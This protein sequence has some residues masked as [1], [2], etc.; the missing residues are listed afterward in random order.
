LLGA[1]AIYVA[2]R[3]YIAALAGLASARPRLT[4]LFQAVGAIVF[5]FVTVILAL[6]MKIEDTGAVTIDPATITGIQ[7]LRSTL[8]LGS[9][10]MLFGFLVVFIPA[11]PVVVKS[12]VMQAIVKAMQSEGVRMLALAAYTFMA[13]AQVAVA[14]SIYIVAT[15]VLELAT[16]DALGMAVLYTLFAVFYLMVFASSML[17]K[18]FKIKGECIADL[19]REVSAGVC[20]RPTMCVRVLLCV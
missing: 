17:G 3:E 14:S 1:Y 15:N 2:V 16:T 6:L 4:L 13:A 10:F 12:K 8:L 5:A 7:F 20:M 11:D 9:I 18:K 19:L